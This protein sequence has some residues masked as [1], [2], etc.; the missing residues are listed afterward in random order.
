ML[1]LLRRCYCEEYVI[2]RILVIAERFRRA[3]IRAVLFEKFLNGSSRVIGNIN[4]HQKSVVELR[5]DEIRRRRDLY[6]LG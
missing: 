4:A 6:R 5:N 1:L 2:V 3:E